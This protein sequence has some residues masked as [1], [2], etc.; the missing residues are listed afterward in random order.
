MGVFSTSLLIFICTQLTAAETL[1][2]TLAGK[3]LGLE[4]HAS[5]GPLGSAFRCM[6]DMV[7]QFGKKLVKRMRKKG[8]C[9]RECSVLGSESGSELASEGVSVLAEMESSDYEQ[10]GHAALTF[11]AVTRPTL[12][13]CQLSPKSMFSS[14]RDAYCMQCKAVGDECGINSDCT[15]SLCHDK[16]CQPTNLV[17]GKSCTRN[18]MCAFGVCQGGVC[19]V[20][21]P[22]R[23]EEKAQREW[24]LVGGDEGA[25]GGDV[26]MGAMGGCRC[27]EDNDCKGGGTCRGFAAHFYGNT[28][29]VCLGAP[30][31]PLC[32]R[33]GVRSHCCSN[34]ECTWNPDT[35]AEPGDEHNGKCV[36][37]KAPWP[38]RHVCDHHHQY[39]A[40]DHH[41]RRRGQIKSALLQANM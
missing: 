19:T 41:H 10:C 1:E 23:C 17:P 12:P 32:A 16:T 21:T 25:G 36:R 40:D 18:E 34:T 37:A 27:K 5:F 13:T 26:D 24:N 11:D 39:D 9:K 28:L 22:D 31:A 3:G 29:G 30:P 7:V 20:V 14:Q 4:V 15:T 8:L 35:E 38:V 2:N 33:W 6:G